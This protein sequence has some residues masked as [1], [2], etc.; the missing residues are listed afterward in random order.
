MDEIWKD[1]PGYEGLYQISS[2]GRVKSVE[3]KIIDSLGRSGKV[4]SKIIKIVSLDNC[5]DYVVLHKEKKYINEYIAPI[6]AEVFLGITRDVCVSHK[7]GDYH[8]NS[9]DNLIPS[10]E[11]Y[12]DNDWR[13]VRGYEGVYQVSKFGQVRSLD[14]YV[15][16]KNGSYR[17]SKGVLRVPDE[18]KDGYL[19]VGLYYT[20]GT[21]SIFGKMKMVHV[22]V[23]EAFIPN[24]ENKT[25]VNHKDG[26]KKNNFVDNL[27]WNTPKENVEHSIKTGL[28]DRITW[29]LEA[30]KA[31][32]DAWNEK[33]KVM[34]R[35]IET[36]QEFDSQSAAASFYGVSTIEISNS[37]R[38]HSTCV[39]VHFVQADEEDYEIFKVK[40]LEGE[41]WKDIPEYESLYQISNL[42]RVKSLPRIVKRTY[43]FRSVPEKLL[44][45][46]GNQVTL[47]KDGVAKSFNMKQLR[48]SI[49]N[50]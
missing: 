24:P 20:E 38:N 10:S 18:T 16:S 17:L 5:S 15:P 33:L 23:A 46:N 2:E 45:I 14:H 3:R 35:C 4:P 22:L 26:N 42:G 7:N 28:R 48:L 13:D 21:N 1:I 43:T 8:D 31:N 6:V 9:S 47:N 40:N 41:I 32:R 27:E 19:Q 29:S 49:F 36:G 50:N 11:Y 12:K 37:V 25:Q 34:V 39:G 44:K 30:A